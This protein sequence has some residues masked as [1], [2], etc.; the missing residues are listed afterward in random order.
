MAASDPLFGTDGVRGKAGVGPLA[1]ESVVRLGAALGSWLHAHGDKDKPALLGGDTRASREEITAALAAGLSRTGIRTIDLGVL[2]TAGIALLIDD[3]DAS[4]AAVISASHN[5]A[6]DNGI[7]V[8]TG[9]G[10]KFGDAESKFVEECWHALAS[11]PAPSATKDLRESHPEGAERYLARLVAA[12]HSPDLSGLTVALDLAHGAASVVGPKLFARLGAK[13]VTTGDRPD[14]SNINSGH[15][16]LHPETV[17][18]LVKRSGADFG[19]AVDGDADRSILVDERGTVVDGDGVLALV[20]ED[21]RGRGELRGG[22]VV[23]TVMSNFGLELFLKERGLELVRTPVGDR[24]VS[25]AL[26]ERGMNL[27]GEPSGHVIFGADL[28]HLGDGLYTAV[29]VAEILERRRLRLSQAT[30]GFEAAP[31]VNVKVSVARRP[32]LESVAG[33]KEILSSSEER[34][35]HE[36]GG[37]VVVRY[38]GTEPVCRVMVEGRDAALV[39]ALA[40]ELAEFLKRTLSAR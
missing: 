28:D 13:V 27:G 11:R 1:R 19:L 26:K 8:F 35:R 31:Q 6:E 36:G 10:T 20:A 38:S 22:G 34:L 2:P 17:A 4:C 15:G 7:K 29:R 3:Y 39:R 25:A 9:H 23:G 12:A 30:A 24:H 5:P 21:L 14:G 37:R 40:Q 33:F 16:S 18:A 32:P